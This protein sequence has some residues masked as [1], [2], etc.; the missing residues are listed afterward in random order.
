MTASRRSGTQTQTATVDHH[1]RSRPPRRTSRWRALPQVQRRRH[2]HGRLRPRL[3]AVREGQ[4]RGSGAGRVRLH[5]A[6]QRPLQPE[7]AGRCRRTRS[8]SSRSTRAT[9]RSASRSRS[10]AATLTTNIAVPVDGTT[11]TGA[12]ATSSTPR[13]AS[14]ETSTPVRC[15]TAGRSSTTRA[16][17]RSGQFDD[18]GDR[19]NLTGGSGDFAIVDSDEY[20]SG[21]AQDTSLVSPV[22]DLSAVDR[23]GDPV[24][25][26]LQ[27][28]R[29]DT[30][31]VDRQHRRRRPPGRPCCTRRPTSAVQRDRRDP[32][33]RRPAS[34]TCRS[35]STTTTPS[36]DW[37]WEVDDVLIGNRSPVTRST[38]ASWSATS[39]DANTN[40]SI[41]GATVT[42]VDSRAEKATTVATPGRPGL[43]DGFY[44]LFSSLTGRHPFTG[45]GRQLRQRRRKT[46]NVEARLDDGGDFPLAAGRL[47]RHA[48]QRAPATWSCP[49]ARSPSRSPSPTRRRAGR[50]RVR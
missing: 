12:R 46:V 31:D 49:P 5:H 26:G 1:H 38:A 47:T 2:R 6:E 23:P 34:P 30:A 10:A 19:G 36:Y 17:A 27:P 11:C 9:R 24:Q 33:P 45:Q 16:T 40:G 37:W 35:G 25:P 4:R 29:G 43:D 14:T 42:S 8:R 21:G 3:A 41:N 48:E 20:G 22:V 39:T 15:P 7:G 50:R 18:P 28:P 44:W 32:L 13:T